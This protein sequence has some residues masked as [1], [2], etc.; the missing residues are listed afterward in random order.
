[1][2]SPDGSDLLLGQLA[3]IFLRN[4]CEVRVGNKEVG[5]IVDYASN[6]IVNFRDV[7][8]VEVLLG[9]C[10]GVSEAVFFYCAQPG[11][12]RYREVPVAVQGVLTAER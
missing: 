6:R 12:L 5:V 7:E 1:M 9:K 2:L 3:Q 11:Q 8:Y 10:S 4:S